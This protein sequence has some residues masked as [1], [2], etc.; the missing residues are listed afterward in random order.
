MREGPHSRR[1]PRQPLSS[2]CISTV[3]GARIE[4]KQPSRLIAAQAIQ[5][6]IALE[7]ATCQGSDRHRRDASGARTSRS[8]AVRCQEAVGRGRGKLQQPTW[9]TGAAVETLVL[10]AVRGR[11]LIIA[12]LFRRVRAPPD[13]AGRI[14]NPNGTHYAWTKPRCFAEEGL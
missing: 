10:R 6:I 1:A 4:A 11:G 8:W 9:D 12:R 7:T 13:G 5:G 2:S 14:R 3:T